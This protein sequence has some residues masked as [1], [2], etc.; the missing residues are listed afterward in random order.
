MEKSRLCPH[1]FPRI[2][3]KIF[4]VMKLC[5]SLLFF[6]TFTLTA[7]VRAQQEKVNLNLK[8]VSIKTLF[9]EI[10][11]Q[12]DLYFVFSAEQTQKLGLFTVKAKD[13]NLESVLKRIFA[14][15]GFVY[16]FNKDLIIVRPAKEA[17]QA[18]KEIRVVGQVTDEKKHPL[19]GVTVQLKGLQMGTATDKDGKYA[20]R[21]LETDRD[22]ILVYS[23]IG[24]ESQEIKYTGKDTIDVVL[25]ESV[26]MLEEV[27]I[28][29][30]YQK[31]DARK[32]TSAITTI[33]AEDI[34]TPG[35]QT[36]DQMLEGYVPGMIFMQNTGQIGAAPRLR[37]RGT[38][39]VLGSQ[40]PLWVVDGV[41]VQDPV[42]VDPKDINDLD[43]VNLLGNAISG[44]NPEDIEQIDVLK[45]ASAT[46]IYG[47]EAANGVIVI[48]TKKG[49][50]GPPTVTYSLSGSFIQRPSYNDKS[51]NMMNSK[52]RIDL[53][54]EMIEK[55]MGFPSVDTWVGYEAAYRDYMNGRLSYDEFEQK[56][57]YYE[58]LNTDWFDILMKDAFSHK[59]T[60]SL[61]GGSSSLRYYA[62]LGLNST[63]GNVRGELNRGYTTSVNISGN[64][65]KFTVTFGLQGNVSKKKYTPNDV[66]ITEF[67][68]NTSRAVPAYNPDGSYWYYSKEKVIDE[69]ELPTYFPVNMLEDRDNASQ[70]INQNGLT[71]Q[72][73]V[74]YQIFPTLKVGVLLSYAFSNSTNATWHGENSYYVRS[75]AKSYGNTE[76]NFKKYSVL[77]IGGEMKE[78]RTDRNA[79]TVRGQVE[80]KEALDRDENH[81][82]NVNA[83]GE[84][85]SNKYNTYA[86]TTRG[87]MKD[88]SM[89]VASVDFAE[90]PAYLEWM[91]TTAALGQY[92]TQTSRDVS[93]FLTTGYSYKNIYNFSFNARADFS[94]EFGSRAKEKFFPIWAISGRWN[95]SENVLK[96][97]SWIND[98][99]IRA[100]F[101]Y[102]GNV[103]QVSPRLVIKRAGTSSLFNE[104][105]SSVVQFPNPDLKWEK[106]SNTNVSV[107]FSLL[108][109]KVN[110]SVSYYY[111]KTTDAYM[112][113][114]VSEVNGVKGYIVNQGTITNQGVE[115][116]LN[117]TPINT[118]GADGKGFRWRF[119]PQ[120]G[121]VMNKL[122]DKAVKTKDKSVRDDDDITYSDYLN[123]TVQTV[124]RSLNGFYSY[125]FLGL[126]PKDGRPMFPNLEQVIGE[127]DDAVDYGE[128]F[129]LMANEERYMSVMKY[130]G[131][132]VPFLQGGIL[133]SFSYNRF[134]LSINL[135]YSIGSKI[136]LLKLYPN[137]S[138]S[139][140]T[141][142]PSPMENAR[143]EFL[144]RW[145]KPGDELN[146][147]IPG[148]LD[149]SEF[150]LT[151]GSFPWWKKS[152][153]NETVNRKIIAENI[154]QMYDYSDIRVVSGDYL[155]IQNISLR[156]NLP[157]AICKKVRMRSAY[158]SLV[159]TNLHTFCNKKL[160]GQDPTT[161]SGSASTISMSIRPTY[162]FSLNVSF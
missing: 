6:F 114:S 86:K 125:R 152:A 148:I 51:V 25:K 160:K 50:Q 11:R 37:I 89:I 93:V 145:R 162:S 150:M 71:F 66:G 90:Y 67:A 28:N 75:L 24:M 47:K 44:L 81:I 72:T 78:S 41:V 63:E 113:K 122:I 82:F 83:G 104:L 151:V 1:L 84:I 132:R 8:D 68:Y 146:T 59:H 31:I 95:L 105:Y 147:K 138:G 32:S 22:M 53:S 155:K 149:N 45:D 34:I 161:Q 26:A 140:S 91:R 17:D 102:Q 3:R 109:R 99:S 129:K 7:N 36:I 121:Q 139:N 136:R 110:G 21:F 60:L 43:F 10:Q 159:G 85:K 14:N 55:R 13:E 79:Y 143:N 52:Q 48:T 94:N 135:S 42:N 119:D 101:G 2:G 30:G 62:S 64:F 131:T 115:I 5:L 88:R 157:E 87:Y 111:R 46:A 112:Q 49:R 97:V 4:L 158:V 106:T 153:Y 128:Q 108:K 96:N 33:K 9:E 107:D 57:G 130:S 56:V 35:L 133:N 76:A 20:I 98:L 61:S 124:K 141:L 58:T 12:T 38:S 65:D 103:P 116:S 154:W 137:V 74:D 15:T 16:E 77:P 29:T 70:E 144:D 100:S 54:R 19:P 69:S 134:T 126:D 118:M 123:G 156:Y 80:Y 142:A 39:T 73:T 40:E 23:F 18:R 120:L 127:G 117:F 27:V 92:I